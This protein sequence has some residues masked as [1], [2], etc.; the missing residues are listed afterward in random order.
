MIE[1][2]YSIK[3]K[4]K[5]KPWQEGIIP[6][7]T[8]S[9]KIPSELKR[10]SS[11]T[12]ESVKL[13]IDL[14]EKHIEVKKLFYKYCGKMCLDTHCDAEEVLME[15]YKGILIRNRGTCPFD[16]KKSAF[17]TYVI[18]VSRCVTA[19][20]INK[21]RRRSEKEVVGVEDTIENTD[22]AIAHSCKS[23]DYDTKILIDDIRKHL[24]GNLLDI[25]ND[26]LLGHNVSH[27]SRRRGL[28]SRK[29]KLHIEKIKRLLTPLGVAPC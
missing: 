8:L 9:L 6:L 12:E 18:M 4:I 29:I 22:Y 11:T 7:Q 14:S 13:G 10:R 20:Y 3:Q 26:L 25:F 15:V 21:K 27:I 2:I 23:E 17:S 28:D 19:N 1:K 24:T 16:A 5:R